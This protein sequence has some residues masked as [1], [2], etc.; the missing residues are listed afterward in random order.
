VAKLKKI[1][2]RCHSPA[3]SER[4]VL[5]V[6]EEFAAKVKPEVYLDFFEGNPAAGSLDA[7]NKLV[8]TW[9]L[10]SGKIESPVVRDALASFLSDKGFTECE[11]DISATNLREQHLGL[12]RD[13]I[14]LFLRNEPKSRAELWSDTKL[15]LDSV[16]AV[17]NVLLQDGEIKILGE[18]ANSQL[19]DSLP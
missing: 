12:L 8:T 11:I 16:G 7:D 4:E 19:I 15:H 3:A 6:L 17:L 5:A 10:V 14:Y 2:A 1:E 18:D 13:V 9:M